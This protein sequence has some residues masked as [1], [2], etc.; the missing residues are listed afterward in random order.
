RRGVS[1]KTIYDNDGLPVDL[2]E[3]KNVKSEPPH[4][5][6]VYKGSVAATLN[7]DIVKFALENPIARDFLN[8]LSDAYMPDE[9]FWSTL[10][11][12]EFLNLDGGYPGRC[13]TI[14]CHGE[15][16]FKSWISR[17]V[18]WQSYTHLKCRKSNFRHSVC[19]FSLSDLPMIFKRPELFANKIWLT[20]DP[21]A[22][23]CVHEIIFNRTH[24][25]WRGKTSSPDININFYANLS[26]VKNYK[27]CFLVLCA[28]LLAMALVFQSKAEVHKQDVVC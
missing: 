15:P 10:N 28:E 17:F 7:R 14:N 8:W 24:D 3:T 19:L 6:T 1:W 27:K 2:Q 9:V 20:T 22:L 12:N 25:Q 16:C 21:V 5:L 23:D 11:H 13:A 18:V 26:A 4:N